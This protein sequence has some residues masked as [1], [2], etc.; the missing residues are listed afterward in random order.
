MAEVRV[1]A[2]VS[3]KENDSLVRGPRADKASNTGHFHKSE[4]G[5]DFSLKVLT[6]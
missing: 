5:V 4:P 2:E 1:E 3:K 6:E